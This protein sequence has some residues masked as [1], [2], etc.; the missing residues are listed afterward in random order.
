LEDF[1][2]GIDSGD[3]E[4]KSDQE[5]KAVRIM[6]MHS[7][8]GCESPIVFL[9]ALEEDIVPGISDNIEEKRRLFYVSLTRAEVG[10]YLRGPINGLGKNT[11][12]Q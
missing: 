11:Y 10:L 9:P 4:S 6:T 1:E 8:K 7:A 5:R 3:L 12:A 2:Q